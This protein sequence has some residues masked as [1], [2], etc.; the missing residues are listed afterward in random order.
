MNTLSYLKQVI[1]DELRA[2]KEEFKESKLLTTAF[3]L[4]LIGL[5]I[6]LKPFPDRQINFLTGYPS[7]DW[8]IFAKSVGEMMQKHGVDFSVINTEGAVENVVRLDDPKDFANAGFTYGLA[9]KESEL[10]GIYSLGS[11]G[12]DP[13]W[14]LYNKKKLGEIQSLSDLARHKVGLGPVKSGSYRIAQKIFEVVNIQVDA[15]SHFVPD[16]M[17]NNQAKIK[18]GE[19]DVLIV[20]STNLDPVAQDLLRS[21]NIAVFDFKNAPAFAKNINS[22][23]TRTLLAD[24]ISVIDKL[25]PKDVTLLATTT[26]LVVKRTMHPDTQL[27]LLMNVKDANRNSP[28]LFFAKR[29]EFPAYLDPS[30]PISPVAEHYYDYGPPHAMKYLPYWLAGFIDRA[31]IL[32]LT[33]LA[34]FYPLSKLNIHLRK[35]RF[36]LKEIPHYKD[37]LA[38]ELRLQQGALNEKEK[39]EMLNRLDEINTHAIHNGVPISEEAAYFNFLNAV[40]LLRI[41]IQNPQIKIKSSLEEN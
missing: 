2:V 13:V 36:N 22:F 12:Y 4:A 37:L 35:F 29:D 18:N 8:N 38:M 30:I 21:P 3:V 19:I 14:I 32:L 1:C 25:P 24:S 33:I 34:V 20:V 9:L 28:N 39:S 6:Y 15:D 7:S 11:V 26:S 41:K 16:S 23:V 27:A 10:E 31:W 40:F 17:L 5:M